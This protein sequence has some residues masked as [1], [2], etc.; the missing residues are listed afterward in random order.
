VTERSELRPRLLV[1]YHRL[2]SLC[3]RLNSGFG[4]QNLLIVGTIFLIFTVHLYT[5]AI[6]IFK[7]ATRPFS[8]FALAKVTAK[9]LFISAWTLH[10]FQ[11]ITSCTRVSQQVNES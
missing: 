7:I 9:A 6:D 8:F 11:I 10:L 1:E 4:L 5:L 2:A 3:S